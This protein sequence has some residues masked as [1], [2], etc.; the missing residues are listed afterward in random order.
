[1]LDRSQP[2]VRRHLVRASDGEDA[3]AGTDVPRRHRHVAPAL[4]HAAHGLPP[5]SGQVVAVA[6][7]EDGV[8][9]EATDHVQPAV[10]GG[11]SVVC[12]PTLEQFG[13]DGR[14]VNPSPLFRVVNLRPTFDS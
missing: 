11:D 14:G 13:Q 10:D 5:A 4:G 2:R 3:G 6:R 12:A 8:A 1:M 7:V 9:V